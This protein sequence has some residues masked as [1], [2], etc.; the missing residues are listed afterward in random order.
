MKIFRNIKNYINFRR[1]V[2]E[3]ID[4]IIS[5]LH[6]LQ[7]N[8]RLSDYQPTI[9]VL[10]TLD[11]F[12]YQWAEFN[13]GAG[14]VDDVKF[15]ASIIKTLCRQVEE[16]ENYFDGKRVLDLGCG[17]G[18]YSYALLKLG[19]NVLS[20]DQSAHGVENVNQLCN[21]YSVRH[22]TEQR[23]ILDWNDSAE[24]DLVYCYGMV[25]HTGN[26]YLAMKNCCN[27]VK[28]GGKLF[29]MI[30][31]TPIEYIDF[32]EINSYNYLRSSLEK[33]SNKEKKDYLIEKF[34]PKLAHGYFDAVSPRIND[35]LTVPEIESYLMDHGFINIK[36]T[37]EGR[38]HEIICVKK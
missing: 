38:N 4:Y 22:S 6:S 35:L 19:A 34:G 2:S 23:N 1:D 29:L 11:S 5:E 31:G 14:L 24:F 17:S 27:K 13:T 32:K 8:N 25:H 28:K 30:Y 7:R 18:R 15:M 10:Q 26:T 3:K 21:R 20:V 12:D 36:K 9:D 37:N 16:E 33:Y